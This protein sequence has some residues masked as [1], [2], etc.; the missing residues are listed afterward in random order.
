MR[1]KSVTKG[2]YQPAL[3]HG[4]SSP[5]YQ[6]VG[7]FEVKLDPAVSHFGLVGF[8]VTMSE[9]R[10]VPLSQ[11]SWMKARINF[12]AAM[13]KAGKMVGPAPTA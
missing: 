1:S 5:H 11:K 6:R 4:L 12:E 10:A 7:V 13:K 8:T 9:L 2:W 3:R